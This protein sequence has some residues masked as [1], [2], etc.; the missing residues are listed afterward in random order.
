MK[1]MKRSTSKHDQA[2]KAVSKKTKTA[3]KRATRWG[4]KKAAQKLIPKRVVVMAG[5][6]VAAVA[7]VIA[8]KKR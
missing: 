1:P 5:G 6:A 7:G 8:V 3:K 4:V 2:R